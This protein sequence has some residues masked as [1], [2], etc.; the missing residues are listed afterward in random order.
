MEAKVSR[1]LEFRI[2]NKAYYKE[3][4]PCLSERSGSD[5][6]ELWAEDSKLVTRGYSF[7]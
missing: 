2:R 4:D 3:K 1:L 7:S 6:T 5:K